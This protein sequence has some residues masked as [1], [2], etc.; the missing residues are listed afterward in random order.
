MNRSA[1]DQ[2]T[3]RSPRCWLLL[4]IVIVVGLSA[5]LISKQWAFDSVAGTPV[6]V[7]RHALV[8]NPD[9]N[10]IPP[11]Q[12]VVA[13]P[14]RLLNFHLV[15]NSG[16]VFG[17]G[18]EQR[19]FFIVFTILAIIV[20]LYIFGWQT[21]RSSLM[22]HLGIGLVMA[23]ALGN[24][25]D[26]VMIGRVRD[27]LHMFPGRQLTF[28]L[29]WPGGGSE[30]FPWIFNIADVLLLLGMGILLIHLHLADRREQRLQQASMKASE[31]ES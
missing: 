21:D 13:I 31:S 24:L 30:I 20:A 12:S 23:G 4:L 15:L 14:G 11:H 7:T 3:W 5:D 6:V 10:P 1:S 22:A 2:R 18:S 17:I 16:A 28:G 29:Q 8:E 19:A 25:W 27:F 26:R 9:F